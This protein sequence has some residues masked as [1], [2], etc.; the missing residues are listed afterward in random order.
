M[1]HSKAGGDALGYSLPQPF[2]AG[3]IRHS[4][5]AIEQ[6]L[7]REVCRF[8]RRHLH[9]EIGVR[10]FCRDS[11]HD[12]FGGRRGCDYSRLV[13]TAMHFASSPCDAQERNREPDHVEPEA[14]TKAQEKE[15]DHHSVPSHLPS[16]PSLIGI[17]RT[18]PSRTISAPRR[19]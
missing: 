7:K 17:G 19:S 14:E 16:G 11:H 6:K 4:P 3:A 9:L 12:H 13:Q 1:G 10:G 8:F 2:L 15:A 5:P 18:R